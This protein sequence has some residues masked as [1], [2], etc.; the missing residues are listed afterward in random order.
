[1]SN[2]PDGAKVNC[3]EFLNE[4]EQLPGDATLATAHALRGLP[5]P[6]R[7]HGQACA[8]CAAA[9]EDFVETRKAL[10]PMKALLPEAGPWFAK[11]VMANI[12]A[13]EDEIDERAN[14]VWISVRRL[15]PRLAAIAVLLLV[16]GGSWAVEIRRAEQSRER[17]VQ[18]V[19]SLFEGSGNT[20]VNY[21]IIASVSE[22][23]P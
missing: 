5:A 8:D 14:G 21:D 4:L 18:P 2:F 9:L 7:A 10:A 13:R 12:S 11:R 17:Q 23:Q 22:E 19:D 6:M 3:E 20:P 15:A 16:I 1:M